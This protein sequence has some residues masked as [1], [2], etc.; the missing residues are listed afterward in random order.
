MIIEKINSNI[1]TKIIS[2][3]PVSIK[4][5]SSP[6]TINDIYTKLVTGK[7]NLELASFK[8]LTSS[9]ENIKA[10]EFKRL[11]ERQRIARNRSGDLT[12]RLTQMK[13]MGY[14]KWLNETPEKTIEALSNLKAKTISTL[15]DFQIFRICLNGNSSK[16]LEALEKEFSFSELQKL[17][18]RDNST[19]INTW[20][21][22]FSA[23]DIAPK[24]L[25]EY[26]HQ[27]TRK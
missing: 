7:T 27:I 15:N 25:T 6:K 11:I 20:L 21:A 9:Q 24:N 5:I 12:Y 18:E 17:S 16:E 1:H 8:P 23:E 14:E 22:E 26:I 4:E 2:K 19:I 13:K 10:L 3:A